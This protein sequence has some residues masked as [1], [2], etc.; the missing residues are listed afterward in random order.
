MIIVPQI[1]PLFFFD[2]EQKRPLADLI[3]S[4]SWSDA[5]MITTSNLL[6]LCSISF[7]FYLS[8]TYNNIF[9][10]DNLFIK[11]LSSHCFVPFA[12][13]SFATYLIHVPLTWFI[14]HQTRFPQLRNE[15]GT[16]SYHSFNIY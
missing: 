3:N 5:L 14:V 10:K 9:I 2:Y 4:Y 8:S 1:F 6:W 16:V 7:I 11:T 15:L 13:I 12:R